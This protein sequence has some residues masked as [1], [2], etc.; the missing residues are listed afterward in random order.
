MIAAQ[1][2]LAMAQTQPL[3]QGAISPQLLQ[4]NDFPNTNG[5][6]SDLTKQLEMLNSEKLEQQVILYFLILSR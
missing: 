4:Q 3:L 6:V 5:N 1:R 2:L